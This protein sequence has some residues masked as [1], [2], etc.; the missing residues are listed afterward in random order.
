MSERYRQDPDSKAEPGEQ[1]AAH[2]VEA[3]LLR[4]SQWKMALE[5]RFGKEE[6]VFHSFTGKPIALRP[7]GAVLLD[8]QDI[9]LPKGDREVSSLVEIRDRVNNFLSHIR[10]RKTPWI[11]LGA[12]WTR[13]YWPHENPEI[14]MDGIVTHIRG[15]AY[16]E[17]RAPRWSGEFGLYDSSPEA[18]S[19]NDLYRESYYNSSTGLWRTEVIR[20]SGDASE[21]HV[22]YWYGWGNSHLKEQLAQYGYTLEATTRHRGPRVPR[23]SEWEEGR[24]VVLPQLKE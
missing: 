10:D 12:G 2:E 24:I 18:V 11:G 19:E 9:N 23:G 14:A 1:K 17:A 4:I 21:Q 20:K 5:A 6:Q 15:P 3:Q 7:D 8:G 22:G 16:L 13:M